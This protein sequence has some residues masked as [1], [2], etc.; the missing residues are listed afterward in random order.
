MR[1]TLDV[2]VCLAE[3]CH[4]SA[5]RMLSNL[6]SVK[7]SPRLRYPPTLKWGL[8]CARGHPKPM[9]TLPVQSDLGVCASRSRSGCIGPRSVCGLVLFRVE[10]WVVVVDASVKRS[11]LVAAITDPIQFIILLNLDF[12]TDG[13]CVCDE[14]KTKKPQKEPLR[15]ARRSGC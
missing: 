4:A 7:I 2:P 12:Y 11:M 8:S 13:S 3:I 14:G 9:N 6:I 15:S 10:W 5:L 1:G